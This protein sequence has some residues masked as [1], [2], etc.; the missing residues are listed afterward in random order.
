MPNLIIDLIVDRV[1]LVEEGANS[2]AFIELYK[3]KEPKPMTVEE[4]LQELSPEHAEVL[5]TKITAGEQAETD[6]AKAKEDLVQATADLDKAKQAA[7]DAERKLPCECEGEADENGVCKECGRTKQ[8]KSKDGM[9]FDET[10]TMKSLPKEVREYLEVAKTRAEA[11]ETELRKARQQKIED[12]AITKAASLKS[13][14][15]D[16]K[17]LVSV[18]KTASKEVVEVLE[19][20]NKAIDTTVLNE[21][22]KAAHAGTFTAGDSNAAWNKIEAEA[23]KLVKSADGKVTKAKAIARIIKEQPELYKQYLDGGAE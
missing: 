21:V 11:A 1:D 5:K 18:L 19:A 14:P 17:V 23:D 7:E 10:E 8:A 20:A 12:D 22:G 3:R 4:I 9:A 2:A 16:Q 13:I 6:L 15:V